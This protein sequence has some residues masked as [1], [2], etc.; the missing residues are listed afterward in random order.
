M[1]KN[2][3]KNRNVSKASQ[4]AQ[5]ITDMIKSGELVAEDVAA[6]ISKLKK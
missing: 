2:T 6:L 4:I 3:W 1:K 5:D